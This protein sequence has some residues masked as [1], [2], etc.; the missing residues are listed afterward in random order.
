M[1]VV[2]WIL[3]VGAALLSYQMPIWICHLFGQDATLNAV[4]A[5]AW[6]DV[7]TRVLFFI[8]YM[9]TGFFIWAGPIGYVFALCNAQTGPATRKGTGVI[10]GFLSA[11]LMPALR[12]IAARIQRG[13][14]KAQ[15]R[16]RLKEIYTAEYADE[17]LSFTQFF[18]YCSWLNENRHIDHSEPIRKSFAASLDNFKDAEILLGLPS[19]YT[20]Q[21]LGS[22]YR[23][24]IKQVHPDIVG[25]NDITR[26]LTL[27]RDLIKAKRGWK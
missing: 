23:S 14:D 13:R 6:P 9:L 2:G 26:R 19:G 12:P 8:A 25:P 15:E 18:E 16:Q 17:F 7:P 27:A 22:R 21:D 11:P 5:A 24:L 3:F 10:L 1:E 4:W 20:A